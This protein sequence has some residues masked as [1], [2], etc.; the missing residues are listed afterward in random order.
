MNIRRCI[1]HATGAAGGAGLESFVELWN[2]ATSGKSLLIRKITLE[3]ADTQV[4]F[5][6]HTSQQGSGGAAGTKGN[7]RWG[8]TAP[9]AALF[10]ASAASVSGTARFKADVVADT[11]ITFDFSDDPIQI[12]EGIAFIIENVTANTALTGAIIEW[13]ELDHPNG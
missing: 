7:K 5:K 2:S 10:G 8:H 6:S 11:P 9:A 4:Q 3:T 13:D 1:G 12:D